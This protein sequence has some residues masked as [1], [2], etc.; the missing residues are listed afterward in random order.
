[1]RDNKAIFELLD[2]L[3]IDYRMVEHEDVHTMED[4]LPIEAQLGAK[5]FRNLFLTNRNKSQLWLLLI[6]GDKP[7]RTSEVSHLL[8]VSRLSFGSAE[9]LEEKLGVHPG[10]VNPL[11]LVFDREHEIHLACDREILQHKQVCMHPGSN[12]QSI[13]M[14]TEDLFEKILPHLGITPRWIDI[15]GEV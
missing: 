1:M 15:T 13:V 12:G 9:L 10:A 6:I 14:N 3:A 2:R 11:S 5:F 8:E 4:L 7:F